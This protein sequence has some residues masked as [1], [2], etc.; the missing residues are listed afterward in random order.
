MDKRLMT[1]SGETQGSPLDSFRLLTVS[2]F[3]PVSLFCLS[4]ISNVS[5]SIFGLRQNARGRLESL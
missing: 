5:A 2:A 4:L 3:S 1:Q